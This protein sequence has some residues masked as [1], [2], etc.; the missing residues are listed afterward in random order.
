M[1]KLGSRYGVAAVVSSPPGLQ[2][3]VSLAHRSSTSTNNVPWKRDTTKFDHLHITHVMQVHLRPGWPTW[4]D[5]KQQMR[6]GK[7]PF[8]F[9][10]SFDDP[11]PLLH[12]MEATLTR[13]TWWRSPRLLTNLRTCTSLTRA[14][15]SRAVEPVTDISLYRAR[16]SP[17]RSDFRG[18]GTVLNPCHP[19]SL[20]TYVLY[21]HTYAVHTYTDIPYMRI[22]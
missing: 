3:V 13:R 15:V 20:S 16:I 22:G 21:I 12:C 1:P 7:I 18:S 11:P 6:M 14:H 5:I 17:E 19:K 2:F 8:F 4:G 9:L 10:F